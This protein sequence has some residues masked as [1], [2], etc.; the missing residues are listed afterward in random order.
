MDGEKIIKIIIFNEG[1]VQN[2]DLLPKGKI[3]TYK[4]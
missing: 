4:C 1:L 2:I 3:Y